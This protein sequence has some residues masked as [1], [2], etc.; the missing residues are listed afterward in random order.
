MKYFML[1]QV[2]EDADYHTLKSEIAAHCSTLKWFKLT[3]DTKRTQYQFGQFEAEVSD[4]EALDA[5]FARYGIQVKEKDS[6]R[7]QNAQ[8]RQQ[9]NRRENRGENRRTHTPHT[10]EAPIA[11]P[12]FHFYKSEAY[13]KGM[14]SYRLPKGSEAYFAIEGTQGFELKTTYP[15]LLV[16]AGY[17]HPKLKSNND[18]FQLGFFFDHTTGLPLISGSSVKGMIRSVFPADGKDRYFAQ[19]VAH[20][21]EAYGVAYSEALV[22]ELFETGQTVFYD[23]YISAPDKEG[24]IFG[25]DFITSHFSDEPEGM[26]KEPNPVK[27]LKVLPDVTFR[28]QFRVEREEHLKLFKNILLD[29]GIGAKTNVG[30]GQFRNAEHV[31]SEDR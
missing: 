8:P 24:K 17:M 18:D 4:R 28:F 15:G 12:A 13:G 6:N 16:G 25:S 1:F 7:Q 3:P 27:F 20:L 11:N 31:H 30:Y 26:L 14:E 21:K 9:E 22:A 23:A 2:P 5:L 10:Q 29:F 19:K